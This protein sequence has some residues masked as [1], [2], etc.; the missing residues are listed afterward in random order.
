MDT[1]AE[2]VAIAN[3]FSVDED[4]HMLP[5]LS[6]LVEYVPTGTFVFAKVIIQ[7]RTKVR[8]NGFSRWTRDVPLNVLR[9][10]YGSHKVQHSNG[11]G[12]PTAIVSVTIAGFRK[13]PMSRRRR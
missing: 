3:H 5:N 9:K 12:F 7:H 10:S 8:A 6:L 2:F 4:N 13:E 1:I 11:K